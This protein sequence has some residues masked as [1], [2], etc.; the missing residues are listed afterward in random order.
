MNRT[1]YVPRCYFHTQPL[2]SEQLLDYVYLLSVYSV[3]SLLPG[4]EWVSAEHRIVFEHPKAHDL[5]YRYV[6]FFM[7]C[8]V[9]PV[10]CELSGGDVVS[11]PSLKERGFYHY[12]EKA[13]W[14]RRGA[15]K[16][17][18]LTAPLVARLLAALVSAWLS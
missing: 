16:S 5:S 4:R 17:G 15:I 14:P 11:I 7:S 2:Q 12:H 8:H 18:R 6:G 10:V 3:L 1:L 13:S 9:P